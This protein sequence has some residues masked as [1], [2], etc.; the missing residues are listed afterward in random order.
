MLLSFE[1]SPEPGKIS[2]KV[3]Q[4]ILEPLSA[5]PFVLRAETD[6]IICSRSLRDLEEA[7]KLQSDNSRAYWLQSRIEA[8]MS[9]VEKAHAAA[10]TGGAAGARQPP[11]PGH[12]GADLGQAGQLQRG[13]REAARRR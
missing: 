10:Q 4:I 13:D 6:S 1:A 8:D 11:V 9:G 2:M 12:A 7:L 5:E 3:T